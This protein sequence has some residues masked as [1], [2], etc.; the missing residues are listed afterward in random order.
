MKMV[1]CLQETAYRGAAQGSESGWS[2]QR[3]LKETPLCCA[4]AATATRLSDLP[5]FLALEGDQACR[6]PEEIQCQSLRL[7]AGPLQWAPQCDTITSLLPV[8]VRA[9]PTAATLWAV[10]PQIG[11]SLPSWACVLRLESVRLEY[12]AGLKNIANTLM[13]KALQEC[14]SSGK[15]CWVPGRAAGTSWVVGPKIQWTV[16][17]VWFA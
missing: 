10:C 14:P 15:A 5:I 4:L 8:A 17:N 3:R 11:T 12:R 7:R 9:A 16:H 6:C 13:A 1:F 2:V